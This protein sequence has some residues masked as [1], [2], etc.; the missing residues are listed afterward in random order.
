[1]IE[2]FAPGGRFWQCVEAFNE[3]Q[4]IVGERLQI[5]EVSL[6]DCPLCFVVV[7]D[8]GKLTT[9][10][11]PQPIDADSPALTPPMTAA[12]TSKRSQ[13]LGALS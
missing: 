12:S 4:G 6:N 10:L 5:F 2:P 8:F 9:E 3:R 7:F 11:L 13:R 1:M